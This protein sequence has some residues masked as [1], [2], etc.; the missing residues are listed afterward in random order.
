MGFV[1]GWSIFGPALARPS[2]PWVTAGGGSSDLRV[3]TP[4]A[5]RSSSAFRRLGRDFGARARCKPTSAFRALRGDSH[6]STPTAASSGSGGA[7]TVAPPCVRT[8]R[9]R[10]T[11][12]IPT[13]P[14]PVTSLTPS[15]SAASAATSS[16]PTRSCGSL[17]ARL[18]RK[19][20]EGR[21]AAATA[22]KGTGPSS[23]GA[24]IYAALK[25]T[26]AVASRVADARS[27][28]SGG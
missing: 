18:T 11:G 10:A 12:A 15:V 6:G 16:P 13:R 22:R 3:R 4:T 1:S 23:S 8:S 9:F 28:A 24:S 14:S 20:P 19:D 2:G 17:T 27:K 26:A 21:G 7:V 25:G 5:R